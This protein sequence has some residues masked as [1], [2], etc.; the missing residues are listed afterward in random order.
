MCLKVSWLLGNQQDLT[1]NALKLV[2]RGSAP[3]ILLIR[4]CAKLCVSNPAAHSTA[5]CDNSKSGC[6]PV[7]SLSLNV[8]H[9]VPCNAQHRL[10]AGCHPRIVILRNQLSFAQPQSQ[11]GGLKL[12]L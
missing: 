5:S 4:I 7:H 11:W 12:A 3:R 9:R 10:A 2:A 6:R 8:V 1:D